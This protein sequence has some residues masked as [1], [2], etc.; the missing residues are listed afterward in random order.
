MPQPSH[1]VQQAAP[2]RR[3]IF[4]RQHFTPYGGG[5]L[6]LD[7]TISALSARGVRTAILGRAWGSR[8]DVEFIRCD[9]PNRS[10]I[11]RDRSFARAACARIAQEQDAVVQSHERIPCCDIFRAGDGVHAAYLAHRGRGSNR[12][13][14]AALS[15][16]PFHRVTLALERRMFASARLKA[17][18]VN[19]SMV[20]DEIVRHFAFPR[21][22]IHLVPNGIDLDRFSLAARAVHRRTLRAQLGIDNV[23]PV[24]LFVGSGYKRKG[25]PAA[26]AALAA[27]GIDAD[28]WVVGADRWPGSYAALARSAGIRNGRLRIFGPV[29]DPLPHYAAADVLILPSVYDP[30]PSTVIEALACGL[31]VVTSTSCGARDAA[32]R[33]DPALVRD[34]FDVAGLADALRRAFALAEKPATADTARGIAMEFGIGGMIERLL[35]VYSRLGLSVNE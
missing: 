25:L 33:L 32:A 35:A 9:P 3:L 34:A 30:F 22:R 12:F 26:V 10:R 4:V 1:P 20:A 18:L 15:L 21:E 11:L 2:L 31:P 29:A 6:I 23:R 28:L 17:V 27:S 7:R 13:A 8:Q 14:R 16:H 5:E 24:A 19:S